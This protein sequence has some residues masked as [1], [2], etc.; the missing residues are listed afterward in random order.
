MYNIIMKNGKVINVNATGTS[1]WEET[2]TLT[3]Y[4][5]VA[6]VGVLNVDNIIGWVKSDYMTESDE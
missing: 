4:N 2:R 5:G 6:T 3:L 1:L